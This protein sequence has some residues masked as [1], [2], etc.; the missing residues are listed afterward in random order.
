MQ[1]SQAQSYLPRWQ[2]GGCLLGCG[3][4]ETKIQDGK[5][6]V[7]GSVG[8]G[9]RGDWPPTQRPGSQG[10]GQTR[11]NQCNANASARLLGSEA[12]ACQTHT[13]F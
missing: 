8:V 11:E 9:V 2:A 12:S 13:L 5:S 3:M 4:T 10:G 1:P 6:F 7:Q